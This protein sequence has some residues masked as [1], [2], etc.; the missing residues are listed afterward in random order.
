MRPSDG[1]AFGGGKTFRCVERYPAG[2]EIFGAAREHGLKADA[3]QRIPVGVALPRVP[4]RVHEHAA[5]AVGDFPEHGLVPA[6]TALQGIGKRAGE[7]REVLRGAAVVMIEFILAVEPC[8]REAAEHGVVG[9]AVSDDVG[10]LGAVASRGI[11][12]TFD[13]TAGRGIEGETR[14]E[15]GLAPAEADH[16]VEF[17]PVG[18]AVVGGVNHVYAAATAHAHPHEPPPEQ[19]ELF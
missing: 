9:L 6:A 16:G 11:G 2:R 3:A 13:C 8:G 7:D 14:A 10:M 12:T 17:G 15:A 1:G 19:T 4:E 5:L 18:K